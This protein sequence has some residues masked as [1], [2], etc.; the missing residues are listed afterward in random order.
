MGC[1]SPWVPKGD[2]SHGR[3]L[4]CGQCWGC[5][6]EHSRQWAIRCVHEAQL[7][8]SNV[9]VTLTYAETGFT[10]VP[11]DFTLFMKRLRKHFHPR[12]I[13]FYMGAEY[14]EESGRPHFHA[15]LFNCYFDDAV[16]QFKTGAG[17]R[18]Y[19]SPTLTRLWG[20][21]HANFGDVTFE[22]AAY[23]AR[24]VMKKLT[25]DGNS[26]MYDVID[27][28]SGEVFKRVKEYGRMSLKPGIGAQWLQK[29]RPDVY[30]HGLV[31]V[32]G[33]E[34]RPPRYYDKLYK[35]SSPDAGFLLSARR[36]SA[37][38]DAVPDSVPHRLEAKEIVGKARLGRLK[39]T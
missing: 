32:N 5:R 3:P 23:V 31:V 6:L 24:Y 27:P 16:Y 1:Y 12:L 30:P 34:V 18:M 36:H 28:D 19:T 15:C 4:S 26:D 11:R 35:K 2:A 20:H 8:D 10:L 22:S 14:G 38:M 9:F 37:M 33:K 21:G 7:Y 25:G 39:R 17:F 13:R 29:F